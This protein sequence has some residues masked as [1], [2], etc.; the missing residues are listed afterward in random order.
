MPPST[1]STTLAYSVSGSWTRD[2]AESTWRARAYAI[3]YDLNLLSNFTYFLDDPINGDQFQ[4]LD[5]RRIYGGDLTYSHFGQAFGRGM[6]HTFGAE[7]R[8]DDIKQVALNNTVEGEFRANVRSDRV[9]Q[10]SVGLFYENEY[11]WTD[12]LRPLIG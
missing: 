2:Q 1:L 7:L 4:Q 12:R 11:Q 3:R 9:R 6:A 10:G 8:Y 5:D